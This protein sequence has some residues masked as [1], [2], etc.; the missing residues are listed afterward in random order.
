MHKILIYAWLYVCLGNKSNQM[1]II[2][3]YLEMIDDCLLF[4]NYLLTFSLR[5]FVSPSFFIKHND[6]TV[7]DNVIEI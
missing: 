7:C 1:N 2:M 6:G 3:H 4:V 5:S